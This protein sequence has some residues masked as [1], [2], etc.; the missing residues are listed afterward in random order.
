VTVLNQSNRTPIV[1]SSMFTSID[2]VM[3]LRETKSTHEQRAN[4]PK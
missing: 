3:V 2:F 4:T 1:N